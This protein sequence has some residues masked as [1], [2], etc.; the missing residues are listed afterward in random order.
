[1]LPGN[2]ECHVKMFALAGGYLKQSG[3]DVYSLV[4]PE[5]EPLMSQYGVNSISTGQYLPTYTS[6][7][8]SCDRNLSLEELLRATSKIVLFTDSVLSSSSFWKGLIS[9]RFDL[10]FV[11]GSPQA[12][13]LYIIPYKLSVRYVTLTDTH[14]PWHAGIPSMPSTETTPFSL[15]ISAMSVLQRIGNLIFGH[16][17]LHMLPS[18]LHSTNDHLEKHMTHA[19]V[20][21]A[22]L[23]T[24]SEI[25]FFVAGSICLNVP[26]IDAPHYR[27][28][29]GMATLQSTLQLPEPVEF[30]IINSARAGL[31]VLDMQTPSTYSQTRDLAELLRQVQTLDS[32][33][34]NVIAVLHDTTKLDVGSNERFSVTEKTS[35]AS[36]MGR[37][38]VKLL[39]SDGGSDGI[40]AALHHAVPILLVAD[41]ATT[42]GTTAET[43]LSNG[44][45][46]VIE[47]STP[48]APALSKTLTLV[49]KS[50][51][52]N[53]TRCSRLSKQTPSAND[54]IVFWTDHVIKHGGAHLRLKSVGTPIWKLL[55]L[56][57]VIFLLVVFYL[58]LFLIRKVVACILRWRRP[59]RER[60]ELYHVVHSEPH[61][62]YPSHWSSVRLRRAY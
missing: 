32:V 57:V 10:A 39:I 58:C 43:A 20:T 59:S 7:P 46:K 11:D 27:P 52:E 53:V 34:E 2:E 48:T 31:I 21:I 6:E 44:Y 15:R 4:T 56:D 18:I 28:L 14:Q 62:P 9:K 37:S 42:W 40:Y 26:I 5:H 13:S 1:M 61:P 41:G 17:R 19:E 47:S 33:Q 25:C 35:V 50:S 54:T 45:A 23:H 36:I 38:P 60:S 22:D 12:R 29:Y 49:M 16:A 8:G 55:M 3:H 30:F 51:K 24:K